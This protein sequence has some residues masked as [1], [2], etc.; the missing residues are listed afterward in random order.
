MA[1]EITFPVR[2][3]R[4]HPFGVEMEK[5]AKA[6]RG[7]DTKEITIPASEVALIM[8]HLWNEGFPEGLN[9][10]LE[11]PECNG[12]LEYMNR[13]RPI[14]EEKIVPL[15]EAARKAGMPMIHVTGGAYAETYPQYRLVKEMVGPEPPAEPGCIRTDWGRERAEECYGPGFW[16]RHPPTTDTSRPAYRDI[17]ECAKPRPCDYMVATG[18]QLNRLC[19][20]LGVWTLLYT[21]FLTNVCVL[22]SAGG[23]LDMI[24]R[25]YRTVILRDCTTGGEQADTVDDMV[26]TRMAIRYIE[27][28]NGYSAE[29]GD[30]LKGVG[31]L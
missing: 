16:E 28:T 18:H 25:G 10:A 26:N 30:I 4:I 20:G 22:H 8:M 1:K 12:Y 29:S 17:P 13:A 14:I 5:P 24:G 6:M 11:H 19:R 9:P 21:G 23:M 31:R 2:F 7:Y 27:Y 3:Y 15:S